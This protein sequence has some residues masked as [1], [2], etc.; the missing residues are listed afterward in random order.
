[1]ADE[2]KLSLDPN[3]DHIKLR[4]SKD[5]EPPSKPLRL[6]IDLLRKRSQAVREV[7]SKLNNYVCTNQN[8]EEERDPGWRSYA[9]VLRALRQKGQ[10]LRSALFKEDEPRSQ[11]LF[12]AIEDLR[13]GAEL[14]VYF[15][16]MRSACRSGSSLKAK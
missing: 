13:P 6:D 15:P 7:L 12:R 11:E 4:W 16:T 10:A 14:R 2:L 1:M 3:G 9:G 8:L 5:D